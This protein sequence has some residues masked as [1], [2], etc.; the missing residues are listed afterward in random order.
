VP[1]L[2]GVLAGAPAVLRGFARARSE[3]RGSA[4][5]AQT[6]ARIALAVAAHHGSPA[7]EQHRRAARRDARLDLDEVARAERFASQ[8]RRH[9]ALLAW[10]RPVVRAEGPPEEHLHEAALEAGWRPQELLE[11]VGCAGLEV[12]GAMVHVA[13]DVPGDAPQVSRVAA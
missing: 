10:L 8:D 7:L 11:A 1:N 3:L 6:R 13:G 4:L 12:F 2:V 5:T 9:A